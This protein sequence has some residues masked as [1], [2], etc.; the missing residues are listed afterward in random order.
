MKNKGEIICLSKRHAQVQKNA[1]K[2]KKA[3]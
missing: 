1:L 2:L 3:D